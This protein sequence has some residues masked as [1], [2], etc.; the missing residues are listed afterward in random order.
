MLVKLHGVSVGAYVCVCMRVVHVCPVCARPQEHLLVSYLVLLSLLEQP[1]PCAHVPM[2]LPSPSPS[3][4]W[5][6]YMQLLFP[7]VLAL[8]SHG[9]AS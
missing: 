8:R 4:C 3:G 1:V 5:V 7:V 2:V 6:A 9:R